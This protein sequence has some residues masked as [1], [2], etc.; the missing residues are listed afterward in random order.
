[1]GALPFH[2]ISE[3]FIACQKGRIPDALKRE[4]HCRPT[5]EFAIGHLTKAHR[6]GWNFV[7]HA[8]GN[9]IYAIRAANHHYLSAHYRFVEARRRLLHSARRPEP[10]ANLSNHPRAIE[11]ISFKYLKYFARDDCLKGIFATTPSKTLCLASPV[12]HITVQ[13]IRPAPQ[14]GGK[15]SKPDALIALFAQIRRALHGR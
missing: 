9:A 15:E 13:G 8:S 5:V 7:A 12:S 6:V 10:R 2:H 14:R 4:L 11:R 3:G 1:V